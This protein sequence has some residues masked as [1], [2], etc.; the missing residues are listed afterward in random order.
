MPSGATRVPNKEVVVFAV[1]GTWQV[2]GA[3]D[4][5]QL[6][7]VADTVRQQPGFVRGYWGQEPDDV[8]VA[9]AVVI[10]ES[11]AQAQTMAEGVQAA[12]SSAQLRVIRVLADA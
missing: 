9:H 8:T 6:A 2:D 7:H 1:I 3:L 10:L 5:E 12:I 4:S 11:E